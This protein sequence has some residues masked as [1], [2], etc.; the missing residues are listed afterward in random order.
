[1]IRVLH[2]LGRLEFGG[3][4]SWLAGVAGSVDPRE[5]RMDFLVHDA[6]PGALDGV[7]RARGGRI[8]PC[9]ID[10][11]LRYPRRFLRILR[12]HGPYD[13]VHSHVHHFSGPVLALARLGGVPIRIA[14]S[15]SDTRRGDAAAGALRRAY[16]EAAAW[17]VRRSATVAVA[18]SADAASALFGERWG[19]DPSSLVV[20]C[21]IDLGRQPARPA[22]AELRR[23]LGIAADALVLGHVGRLAPPKNHAF[24]VEVLAA[25]AA[26]EPRAR[27]LLVGGGPLE[28]RIRAAVAARGL[29]D[30]VV[31]TGPRAD[32]PRLLGAMDLF[33]FPSLWE[34]MPLSLVEAQ[35]AGLPCLVSRAVTAEATVVE[36]LV[37]R[38]D[39]ALGAAAWAEEALRVLR[40]PR[41]VEP[42]A[43]LARVRASDF[44]LGASARA[45]QSI[46]R[47]A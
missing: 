9:P 36:E 45:L 29:A 10:E 39:L 18:A 12:E 20:H 14:H 24:L 4:E 42:A 22:A 2:V 41:P 1:V 38:L 37:T 35:A 6:R 7:V 40:A 15:H 19:S 13:V 17:L 30:R 3:V 28:E 11:P 47:A 5:V 33:V 16:L 26:R 21:G 44:E 31:L 23:E 34:G 8:L 46:Y 27:L 43:A 25:V 32:V